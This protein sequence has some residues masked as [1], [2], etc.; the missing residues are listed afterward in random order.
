MTG[1]LDRFPYA[2]TGLETDLS[3]MP[4][5]ARRVVEGGE[6]QNMSEQGRG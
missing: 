2:W 3:E 4:A 1:K 6:R 5:W